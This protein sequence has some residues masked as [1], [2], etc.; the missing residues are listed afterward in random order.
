MLFTIKAIIA[1]LALQITVSFGSTLPSDEISR[2]R[3]TQANPQFR[4]YDP[5]VDIS[6][7]AGKRGA[8]TD[9]EHNIRLALAYFE[10]T[11]GV[12]PENV[13]ITAAHVNADTGVGHVYARQTAGGVDVLNA[14]AN[15][16][17]D[18]HGRVISSS[19][20]FAPVY[21]VRKAMRS[22][23]GRLTARSRQYDSLKE[24]LKTLC[25]RVKPEIDDDALRM[26]DISVAES[27]ETH[28][29]K[30]II[31]GIPIN[32]AVN[33]V[34]TAQQSMMQGSDGALI[35]VWDLSL[36]QSNHSWNARINMLTGAIESLVDRRFRSGNYSGRR[37][38]VKEEAGKI[39]HENFSIGG[40]LK[41]R[42]SYKVVPI[43]KQDPRDG[44]DFVV[45]PETAS[46]PNGWVY[47]DT[48]S[49]NN[50]I[51][52]KG[53]QASVAKETSPHTF[54]YDDEDT[55]SPATPQNVGAAIT[56]VFYIVNS[57]H[58]IFYIYGFT[59]ATYN[60]QDDNF[61]KGGQG[62]D[63]VFASVQDS[64]DTNN[65]D[66]TTPPDGQSGTLRVYLWDSTNPERDGGLENDMITQLY[67]K[68]VA[69]RLTG[70][71][72]AACLSSSISSGLLEG[73]GDT[74]AE[75]LEQTSVVSDFTLGSYVTNT[76]GGIRSHP[77]SRDET[78][79][80]LTY[81]DGPPSA[82]VHQIG[83][84]WANMLHNIL[85]ALADNRGW[86]D[87]ALTDPTGNL[88]NV[89]FMH[90]LMD[91][92]SI[93]PCEPTFITARDA[94]LQ[95]DQ[96]RY[97]GDHFCILWRVFASRGLGFG[98]AEDNVNEYSVPPGC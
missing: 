66:F 82:E 30:F 20:T 96:N 75:W 83:E 69:S 61:G 58:D 17:I 23:H 39:K 56:N 70:G 87:T 2:I 11:H 55:E 51:A 45:D 74:F 24:A 14:V 8:A 50:V 54:N 34:A 79:N 32:I 93:Q 29:P 97:N 1:T 95:A 91:G 15:V 5:P 85:A 86:S 6:E 9:V 7:S 77:Y 22:A 43:T 62:N 60:F 59:E 4:V 64:A 84:V 92:L 42:L 73:W 3:D 63:R 49:G 57:L 80:P 81:T 65:A 47:S 19:Q 18:R 48:T 94:I 16:N 88:G 67:G 68:G 71:G 21:Q 36:E 33:G 72:T 10:E 27:D 37:R 31:T 76:P 52:Y 78:V 25:S 40:V 53:T 13:R 41:K 26:V 46:S 35:H 12:S 44:F 38:A 90:L 28:A 98:A 89:V